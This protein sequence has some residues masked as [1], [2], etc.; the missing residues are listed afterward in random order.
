MHQRPETNSDQIKKIAT[1]VFTAAINSFSMPVM[2]VLLSCIGWGLTQFYN[3]YKE[4][5]E[6]THAMQIS[7]KEI[8]TSLT[9]VERRTTRIENMLDRRTR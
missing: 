2:V 6:V 1:G 9:S 3:E 5:S 7:L 8:Y 4:N